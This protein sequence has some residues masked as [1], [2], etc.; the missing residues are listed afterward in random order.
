MEGTFAGGCG[1][2]NI[3]SA[4]VCGQPRVDLLSLMTNRSPG[5]C[6]SQALQPPSLSGPSLASTLL[7]AELSP[8][9]KG[10]PGKHLLLDHMAPHSSPRAQPREVGTQDRGHR[11]LTGSLRPPRQ[12]DWPWLSAFQPMNSLFRR[13][14][15][16]F[17]MRSGRQTWKWFLLGREGRLERPHCGVG[18]S[19]RMSQA[20]LAL[21]SPLETLR[22]QVPASAV[23]LA[24]DGGPGWGAPS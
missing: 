12:T 5:A 3:G 13:K 15:L 19:M 23:P 8:H 6:V 7:P 17:A 24:G 14:R 4:P 1:S 20:W 9:A 10:A 16:V 21:L 2:I 11:D 22:G 18:V